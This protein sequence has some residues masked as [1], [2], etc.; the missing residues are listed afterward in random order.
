MNAWIKGMLAAGISG[1]AGGVVNA[2][3]AIGIAPQTFNLH[4]GV[5]LHSTLQMAGA[6]AILSA[7]LGLAMYLMKS[8]LPG[9]QP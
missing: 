9:V 7:A 1:A 4:P 3:S 5:G 2:F 8:P 6:G